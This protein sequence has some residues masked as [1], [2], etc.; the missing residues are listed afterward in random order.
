MSKPL[1][2][3]QK[4]KLFKMYLQTQKNGVIIDCAFCRSTNIKF[5]TQSSETVYHPEINSKKLQPLGFIEVN[6][7]AMIVEQNA[8]MNKNGFLHNTIF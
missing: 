4:L 8:Q 6:I 1:T 5:K 7:L 2:F 3:I